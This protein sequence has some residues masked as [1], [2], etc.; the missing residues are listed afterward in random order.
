[1]SQLD[2][3]YQQVILDHSRARCGSGTLPVDIQTSSYQVNPTCGDEV[4]LGL[5]LDEA[6]EITQ[7]IWDGDGCSISQASLSIM[8]ELLEGKSLAEIAQ[9]YDDFETMMHSRGQGVDDD[10]LDRIEDGAALEGTSKFPNR[11]KC[12]LLGWYALKDA[13]AKA[14]VALEEHKA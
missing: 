11:I 4:T 10:L 6:G 2:V 5:N 13:L 3:M 7:L 8:S 14:G 12:A 1:M 9:F